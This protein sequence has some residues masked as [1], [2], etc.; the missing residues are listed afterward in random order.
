MHHALQIIFKT[1]LLADTT[2]IGTHTTHSI[3]LP[4]TRGESTPPPPPLFPAPPTGLAGPRDPAP[5]APAV[6]PLA[7]AVAAADPANGRIPPPQ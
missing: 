7:P 1:A 5:L 3:A 6:E 2:Q 4:Q